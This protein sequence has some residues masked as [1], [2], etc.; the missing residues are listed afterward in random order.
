V[1]AASPDR[2]ALH[3][4]RANGLGPLPAFSAPEVLTRANDDEG[5]VEAVDVHLAFAT[6]AA[7]HRHG[8]DPD[9]AH[10]RQAHGA[11]PVVRSL[12]KM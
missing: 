7:M 4:A 8:P 11:G 5:C 10:V 9:R 1:P 2:V 3:R 6:A 12:N